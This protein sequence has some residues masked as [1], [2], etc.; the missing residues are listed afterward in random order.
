MEALILTGGKGTRLRP[1]TLYSPKPLLPIMNVPFLSYPSAL[2]RKAGVRDLVLCTA[3]SLS[4]YQNFVRAEAR[5]GTKVYCSRETRALGTAGAIKNAEKFIRSE[6]F[7]VLNG[8]VL[9][10]INLSKMMA[11]HAKRNSLMTIALVPVPDPTA[12]GLIQLDSAGKIKNFI[13]KPKRLK[14]SWKPP[15]YINAGIYLFNRKI[16]DLIPKNENCSSERQVFPDALRNKLPLYGFRAP[17]P[18]WIDI[19][20]P[21]KY[22]EANRDVAGGK[23]KVKLPG[24]TLRGKGSRVHKTAQIRGSVILGENCVIEPHAVLSNCVLLDKIQVH[25]SAEVENCIIGSRTIIG[26]RS[27][28]QNVKIIGNHSKITPFSIL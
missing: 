19:G 8:D 18:Y 25:E 20:T 7:F 5:R 4:P 23:F 26:K 12:Y 14:K 3:D 21:D 6:N 9:T 1:L 17:S 24:Q 2:L 28:V 15:Y 22:L 11:F 27:R 16:F 13:E 10:D